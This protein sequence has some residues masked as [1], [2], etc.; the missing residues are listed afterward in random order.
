MNTVRI[1]E[2]LLRAFKNSMISDEKS[3]GTVNKYLHDVKVFGEWLQGEI[4][5]KEAA[6]KWKNH[7]LESGLAAVTVNSMIAA[8]NTFFRFVGCEECR[9]RLLRLQKRFF[10]ENERE[11]TKKEYERL[12]RAAYADGKERLGLLMETMCAT[13]IR[14]SEVKYITCHAVR[15][16]RAEIYLKGKQRIILIPDKLQRK[17]RKYAA[18]T[19]ITAG[20]IFVSRSGRSLD[21]RQI[22]AEMK[23]LCT[24]AKVAYEKVFPH[25]LRH[26][27]ARCFYS[28]CPDPMRLADVMGHSNIET[29]RIYLISTEK[30]HIKK[31][32]RLNLVL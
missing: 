7:L 1:N 9:L 14:V 29:T 24:L 28:I 31:T 10:R 8:L 26:L 4:I 20:E 5:T 21:R 25:N 11:L 22:W 15:K 18:K 2:D 13:G 32:A 19:G 12:I 16:G 27:F 6:V 30:E 3:E 17:L 23:R